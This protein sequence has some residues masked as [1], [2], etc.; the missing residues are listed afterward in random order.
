MRYTVETLTI[1]GGVDLPTL[2]AR[3]RAMPTFQ[4]NSYLKAF[5]GF[6]FYNKRKTAWKAR[7]MITELARR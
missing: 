5:K 4:I 3:L 1:S 7:A 2:N 6:A